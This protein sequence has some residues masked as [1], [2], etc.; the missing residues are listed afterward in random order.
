M[1]P[2]SLV[3]PASRIFT[4]FQ[5]G[6]PAQNCRLLRQ[7][8][9]PN[10][11][12]AYQVQALDSGELMTIVQSCPA[13]TVIG[14]G[15]GKMTAVTIY[16]RTGNTPHPLAPVLQTKVQTTPIAPVPDAVVQAS[17]PAMLVQQSTPLPASAVPVATASSNR[18]SLIGQ[19]PLPM[20]SS[21]G[22]PTPPQG[23][24]SG[25]QDSP[26]AMTPPGAVLS[27]EGSIHAFS[28]RDMAG[29]C[30]TTCKPSTLERIKGIFHKNSCPTTGGEKSAPMGLFQDSEPTNGAHTSTSRQIPKADTQQPDPL[31]NPAAYCRS[32]TTAELAGV[33]AAPNSDTPLMANGKSSLGTGS[34][35]QAGDPRY[36]QV[37]I[38]TL[39][40]MR[41][42]P[43]PSMAQASLPPRPNQPN[44]NASTGPS[45]SVAPSMPISAMA[46]NRF[47][48]GSGVQPDLDGPLRGE[49]IAPAGYA[50]QRYPAQQRNL[51]QPSWNGSA[52]PQELFSQLRDAQL[53]SQREWAAIKL[54]ELDWHQHS[55]V[56]EALVQAAK[57]DPAA[58]VRSGCIHCL[59]NM[60]AKLAS[61]IAVLSALRADSD[62]RVQHEA[63]EALAR[64]APE[65]M[66][67]D[68]AVQPAGVVLPTRSN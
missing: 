13:T 2:A 17:P 25:P 10:G 36:V 4:I 16:H 39:P 41:R 35:L 53:P 42:S 34:V 46:G 24:V 56:V 7:W 50:L 31:K 33:S 14:S 37:P 45:M 62:P 21:Q 63:S 12:E 58:S 47:G 60:N 49:G 38:V 52:D 9:E 40:D 51:M 29:D 55:G 3:E 68:S 44:L 43:Q 65:P 48:I 57:E 22:T 15:P 20:P 19:Q 67:L 59:A 32:R 23:K 27:T 18:L 66:R 61:V 54:A 8:T 1:P 26:A 11:D 30:C 5:R 6:K 64:L 28:N